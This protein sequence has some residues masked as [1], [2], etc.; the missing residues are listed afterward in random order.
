MNSPEEEKRQ[1][2]KVMTTLILPEEQIISLGVLSEEIVEKVL[3]VRFCSIYCSQ[4]NSSKLRWSIK[5]FNFRFCILMQMEAEVE[6]L[7]KL[8]TSRLK[9][10]VM[11]RRAELE[12]ICQN[13]HI[14]HDV[15]TSPEESDA[16][17]DSGIIL[18]ISP[19]LIFQFIIK[20]LTNNDFLCTCFIQAS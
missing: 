11:K 13:A 18:C 8:K 7:T 4:L 5:K 16:M 19:L 20:Y 10:I 6:R 2:N 9:E 17:I 15:S 14:E 3:S 12:E 1:F